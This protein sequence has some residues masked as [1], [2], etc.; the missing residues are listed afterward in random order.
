MNSIEDIAM[1]ARKSIA[2]FAVIGIA[3]SVAV[4]AHRGAEPVAPSAK[5]TGTVAA[6]S[7][8]TSA[9]DAFGRRFRV[10][11]SFVYAVDAAR[12]VSVGGERKLDAGLHTTLALTLVER[13]AEGFTVRAE[14]REPKFDTAAPGARDLAS[15]LSRPFVFTMRETGEIGSFSFPKGS[16]PEV[17]GLLKD[18]VT[19]FQMVAPPAPQASWQTT[20]EDASGEYQAS[21]VKRTGSLHKSKIA[22]QRARGARGLVPLAGAY[23]VRS[24]IDFELDASGWPRAIAEDESL[25][26]KAGTMDVLSTRKTT[27]KLL[28]ID[29]LSK[30]ATVDPQSLLPD[31]VG[32]AEAF[33]RAK[34]SA[35]KGLVGGR[36]FVQIADDLRSDSVSTRN[37]ATVA[38][39]ALFRLEPEATKGAVDTILHGR[40]DEE[41]KARISTALGSAGTPEAQR[42]LGS[43]LTSPDADSTAQ[44]RAAAALG[45]SHNQMAEN[46]ELLTTAMT[47]PANDVKSAATLALGN[48]IRSAGAGGTLDTKGALETLIEG[49]EQAKS[50]DEKRVYLEALG[51]SGDADALSAITPYL[52][53]DEL[54]LRTVATFA[55]RFIPGDAVNQLILAA[56]KDGEIAVRSAAVNTV[57]FRPLAPL[58]AAIDGLLR[59]DP[60]E[61]VRL[62]IISALNLKRAEDASVDTSIRWALDNDP[63][64]KVRK[65][66]KQVLATG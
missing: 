23:E 18:L 17:I 21:Y 29:H 3:A 2:A 19:S 36:N 64:E 40:L 50:P 65:L 55:L 34:E 10:G 16:P 27:A 56:T 46:E 9:T 47:S 13:D 54:E 5:E 37:D 24:A 7:R 31:S 43:I 11:D 42:A 6:A 66:A 38:L 45:L 1:R 22:Y 60:S 32:E 14:L 51:N 33:A 49:L 53:S 62:A 61:S 15:A 26:I 63:S 35:A 12:V 8:T 41:S 59:H 25:H 57:R 52:T 48:S 30:V 39:S 4:W 20:E 44:A 58:R 28:A